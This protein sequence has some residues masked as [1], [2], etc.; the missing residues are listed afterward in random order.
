MEKKTEHNKNILIGCVAD[1]FTGAGDAASFLAN[2]GI[3]TVLT[4]GIPSDDEVFPEDSSGVVIAL[5][6]RTQETMAAVKD[7]ISAFEWLKAQGAQ[8]L[9]FKYCSTF[10]STPKGNIGPV[11]DAVLERF[12]M[13]YTVLCPALLVNS[14]TVRD[15]ILYVGGVPLAESHMKHHPLTPM[16]ES[17][18]T[19]LMRPQS[20]YPCFKVSH[21]LMKKPEEVKKQIDGYCRAHSHFSLCVDFF[22]ADHGRA[23]MELFYDL[24]FLTG[25]S[26]LLDEYAKYKT[27]G[28]NSTYTSIESDSKGGRLMFAGSCSVATR[29][30]VR[31]FLDI[32]GKGIMISPSKLLSGEQS[33]ESFWQFIDEN[34]EEDI[35][36]YS[37]GSGGCIERVQEGDMDSGLLEQM[38]AALAK[39]AVD[40]GRTRLIIAGGETSG[41]VTRALGY[42]SFYIG[43]NVAPGVPVMVPAANTKLQLVLKSGNFGQPDFFITAL[44]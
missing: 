27:E 42:Q 39:Q 3:K 34:R 7:T 15:G 24:P 20:K 33:I 31:S 40:S 36:L 26:G 14:R 8:T 23:I 29:T 44:K 18:I 16:W 11:I 21:K 22:E 41:A 9:Y 25:G 1:D 17:D 4:N 32:G 37:A 2:N 43:K 35:L 12:G 5:K 10:D 19:K 6:S 28:R 30:Q 13:Q 38:M